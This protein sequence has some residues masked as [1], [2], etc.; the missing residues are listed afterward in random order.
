MQRLRVTDAET[1]IM[2]LQDE[3]R[4]NDQ[5]RY[6]HRLHG[7]LLVAQGMSCPEVARLLGDAPRTVEYWVSGFEQEGFKALS[8]SPGRGRQSRLSEQQLAEVGQWLRA[9]PRER[10]WDGN[11]WDGPALSACL[12]KE[13]NIE[14]GKR[15]CQRLFRQLDFRYRLPRPEVAKADPQR[16][17]AHKKTR[18]SGGRSRR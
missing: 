18:P 5:S 14:L 6:D 9:S 17:Q 16:Q 12:K 2:A 8:E 13:F 1:M 11:L 7:V 3:I 4:R 10:G 15:Q